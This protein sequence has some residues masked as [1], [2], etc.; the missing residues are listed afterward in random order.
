MKKLTKTIA[1]SVAVAALAGCMVCAAPAVSMAAPAESAPT[2]YSALAKTAKPALE[3][4][5]TA[6]QES[7]FTKFFFD[8]KA[9]KASK[10]KWTSSNK[11]VATVKKGTIKALKKGK[12]TIT[13]TYKGKTIAISLKVKAA[14]KEMTEAE[15]KLEDLKQVL[16]NSTLGDGKFGFAQDPAT[17]DKS[18][19]SLY[20]NPE[21][22]YL[23]F[24]NTWS[25]GGWTLDIYID[26]EG[27]VGFVV[28]DDK[29][30]WYAT[31]VDAA[32]YT[33][34][35]ALNWKAINKDDISEETAAALSKQA[36]EQV[37][38]INNFM[39]THDISLDYAGFIAFK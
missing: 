1:S 9:V 37:A 18:L 32:T 6:G 33:K 29:G 14:Q 13:A 3:F 36:A 12:T 26:S 8:G 22:N 10:C 21:N 11:K 5:L 7:S 2:T 23:D 39:K 4:E 30:D 17:E 15:K 38:E 34:D 20:Y 19:T 28:V 35:S 31:T 24:A 25:E 27:Q 16:L